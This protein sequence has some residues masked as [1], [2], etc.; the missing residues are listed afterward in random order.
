M[1]RSIKEKVKLV[2]KL[3]LGGAM[4]WSIDGD[5]SHGICGE[6]YVLL[7]TINKGLSD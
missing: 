6:D 5:D 3:E 2:K 4:V 7:K 1:C